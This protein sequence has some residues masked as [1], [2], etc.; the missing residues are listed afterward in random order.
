M[1]LVANPTK[2]FEFTPKGT[3]RRAKTIAA[4]ESEINGIYDALEEMTQIEPPSDWSLENSLNFISAVVN[5]VLKRTA[6]ETEDIFEG[7]CDR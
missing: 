7:G 3:P 1:I 2:P 5:G 6:R 4:Y